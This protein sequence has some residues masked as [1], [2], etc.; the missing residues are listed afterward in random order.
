MWVTQLSPWE[1]RHSPSQGR[2]WSPGG[3][4]AGLLGGKGMGRGQGLPGSVTF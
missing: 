4:G 1:E 3:D 2:G